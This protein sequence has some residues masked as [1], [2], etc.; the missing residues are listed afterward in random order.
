MMI[1][2]ITVYY[3]G[4]LTKAFINKEEIALREFTLFP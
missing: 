2:G 4:Y 3:C 1:T